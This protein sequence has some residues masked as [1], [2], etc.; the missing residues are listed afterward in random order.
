MPVLET[1]AKSELERSATLTSC[2]AMHFF[3]KQPINIGIFTGLYI[4]YVCFMAARFLSDMEG[5]GLALGFIYGSI[6][7]VPHIVIL[8]IACGIC[9]FKGR[10][11]IGYYRWLFYPWLALHLLFLFG[12]PSAS[13]LNLWLSVVLRGGATSLYIPINSIL[14]V[15]SVLPPYPARSSSPFAFRILFD[16][17]LL[18]LACLG[19]VIFGG[20]IASLYNQFFLQ[21]NPWRSAD[22]PAYTAQS[23]GT[24]ITSRDGKRMQFVGKGIC[25][26]SHSSTIQSYFAVCDQQQPFPSPWITQASQIVDGKKIKEWTVEGMGASLSPDAKTIAITRDRQ[27]V[28]VSAINPSQVLFSIATEVLFINKASVSWSP[29]SRHFIFEGGGKLNIVD[30]STR[31]KRLLTQNPL[32]SFLQWSPDSRQILLMQPGSASGEKRELYLFS[33]DGKT[34]RQIAQTYWVGGASTPNWSSDGRCIVMSDWKNEGKLMLYEVAT[35]KF[36][37]LGNSLALTKKFS[38]SPDGKKL[39]LLGEDNFGN[40]SLLSVLDLHQQGQAQTIYQARKNLSI[41][42]MSWLDNDTIAFSSWIHPHRQLLGIP[43][44]TQGLFVIQVSS[45]KVSPVAQYIGYQ[46]NFVSLKDN[47][48]SFYVNRFHIIR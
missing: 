28:F 31:R 23:E 37:Q 27:L 35:Q 30:L 44:R 34:Q 21:I 12:D 41:L 14:I 29:D 32:Y 38:W 36:T 33:A 22:T 47:T 18:P 8:L 43:V 2:T 24:Y 1:G 9:S 10:S 11:Q 5:E 48:F 26:L 40:W 25:S 42:G 46:P 19:M 39:A 6:Y 20:S 45:R 4:L 16:L 15:T 17:C 3:Q 13:G 7:F